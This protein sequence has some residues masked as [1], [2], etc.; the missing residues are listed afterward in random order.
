MSS[1]DCTIKKFNPGIYER[2]GRDK[3]DRA[4]IGP[5]KTIPIRMSFVD[6]LL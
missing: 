3:I 1:I 5:F 2:N 4:N 6:A